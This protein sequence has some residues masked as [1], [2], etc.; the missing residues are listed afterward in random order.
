[1]DERVEEGKDNLTKIWRQPLD[2]R[3]SLCVCCCFE[4]CILGR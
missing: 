3:I 2:Y 4:T 1:L